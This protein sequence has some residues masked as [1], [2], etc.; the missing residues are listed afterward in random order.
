MT[1]L[2]R[3]CILLLVCFLPAAA[4][5]EREAMRVVYSAYD[6][7]LDFLVALDK[8]YFTEAG[9]D[10]TPVSIEGG[11]STIIS[12]LHR[13]EVNGCFLAS[14]GAV[15]SVGKGIPL[16]QVAG[17]GIQTF[18]FYV[19]KDSPINSIKDFA[20]RK[21]GNIPK[22][23]GPWLA[24]QYDLDE[25]NIKAQVI[26][27][28]SGSI[29]A[30]LLTGQVEVGSLVPYNFASDPGA[31]RKVHTSTISKYLYNSCGWWF[32]R[33]FIAAN[34]GAIEKFVRGLTRGR[35]FIRDHKGEAVAVLVKHMKLNAEDCQGNLALPSFD[36]PVTIYQYGLDRT[37]DIVLQYGL[38]DRKP[39]VAAMV[40][41]R[42]ATVVDQ[43]Y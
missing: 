6:F 24:L 36:L 3:F 11:T 32:K 43:P 5:A 42:F 35:E 26:P 9:L 25:Q 13:N 17:I 10:L 41:G 34:P 38:I 29:M 22:P 1:G 12:T 31:L 7:T 19:L 30:S 39:D 15:V 28:A 27:M 14:S 4:L 16:V 23:S 2:L 18:D 33:D 21:I 40:D 20:G 8:G 37:A